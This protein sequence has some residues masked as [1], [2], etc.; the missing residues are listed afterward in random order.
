M[1]IKVHE[2]IRESGQNPYKKWF[3]KLAP[4][5]AAKVATVKIRMELGHTSAIKW[6]DGLGEYRIHWGAGFRIYLAKDGDNLIVLF[7]GGD[8]STQHS[9]IEKAKKL[10]AE[11]RQRKNKSKGVRS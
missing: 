2:Y 6:F 7:G 9:D 10:L 3:D 8:K 1:N 5:A 4:Q 11:Y